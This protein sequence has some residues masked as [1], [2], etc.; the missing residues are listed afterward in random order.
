MVDVTE[1]T[2]SAIPKYSPKENFL[3]S[4]DRFVSIDANDGD[5]IITRSKSFDVVAFQ[6]K[7]YGTSQGTWVFASSPAYLL[8]SNSYL[9][10]LSLGL[11]APN[12]NNLYARTN[13][14]SFCGKP[15]RWNYNNEELVSTASLVQ[16]LLAS[17][18]Q[19]ERPLSSNF[20]SK[21]DNMFELPFWGCFEDR[22][23]A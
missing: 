14:K 22:N 12:Y 18:T 13:P 11:L 3:V 20:Y 5:R 2:C 4:N 1:D 21:T 6:V 8:L 7:G 15:L 19:P 16:P 23:L 10:A 9:A 17:S